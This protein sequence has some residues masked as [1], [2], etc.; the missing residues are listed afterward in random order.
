ML[1]SLHKINKLER[2]VHYIN[3]DINSGI[4]SS[5]QMLPSAQELSVRY[6]VSEITVKRAL[7][8]LSDAGFLKRISGQGTFVSESLKNNSKCLKIGILSLAPDIATPGVISENGIREVFNSFYGPAEQYFHDNNCIVRHLSPTVFN[9][10]QRLRSETSEL[11]GIL[12]SYSFINSRFSTK[13][14][15]LRKPVVLVQHSLPED[16]PFCHV[17][18]DLSPVMTKIAQSMVNSGRKI[19]LVSRYGIQDKEKLFLKALSKCGVAHTDIRIENQLNIPGDMGQMIGYQLGRKIIQEIK[20][21][22][23]FSTSDF[24]SF[25]IVNTFEDAK[26]PLGNIP[27]VSIDDLE[28]DGLLPFERPLLTTIKVSRRKI[29][30]CAAELLLDYINNPRQDILTILRVKTELIVRE[31]SGN[32]IL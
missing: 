6:R 24:I 2:V 3:D 9:D 20:N 31:S 14:E 29:S 10:Y 18:P 30:L 26:I 21:P 22:V 5:G 16:E 28:G 11:D 8:Y 1:Q 19:V 27:L 32:L 15:Q 7:K 13:L 25:G 4:Y 23:I 17:I 12:A